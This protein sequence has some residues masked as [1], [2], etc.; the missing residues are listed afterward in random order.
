MRLNKNGN[1]SAGFSLIELMIAMAITG[2]ITA[3]MYSVFQAQVQG[4]VS[5]GVS[6]QM[7][8]S[9]RAAMEIMDADLRMAGCDPTEG[10]GSGIE[11]A[12]DDNI[13]L[14][15]DI[16][17]GPEG[18]PDGDIDDPNERVRYAINTLDNLGRATGM[19]NP[20]APLNT[21]HSI[22]L[23]CDV[24]NFVYLTDDNDGDG[25]PD[26]LATPVAD[27]D[28]IVAVQVSIILRSADTA[29]PGF[30]RSYTD[31][32]SYENLQGDEILAPQNDTFRRFQ[33]STTIDCRN[34]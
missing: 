24:L 7:T 5:Q 18:Q 4:Q 12:E 31:A 22:D 27:T 34:L 2:I 16:G 30:L 23:E 17:G 13:V 9:V 33:L 32:T 15:M 1:L 28:D 21:L 19:A 11:T 20:P 25:V 8:Q 6:L 14:S 29:N 3:A 10:A 26:V